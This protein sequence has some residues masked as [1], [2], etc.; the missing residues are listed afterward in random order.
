MENCKDC[1][2]QYDSTKVNLPSPIPD[3]MCAICGTKLTEAQVTALTTRLTAL[4]NK[5]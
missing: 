4:E 3:Y 2:S 5:A 1:N